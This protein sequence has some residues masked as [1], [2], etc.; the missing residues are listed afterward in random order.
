MKLALSWAGALLRVEKV[1]LV[2]LYFSENEQVLLLPST[3]SVMYH[4]V[5]VLFLCMCVFLNLSSTQNQTRWKALSFICN[6]KGFFVLLLL[7]TKSTAPILLLFFS[8]LMAYAIT[9]NSHFF[10]ATSNPV[11]CFRHRHILLSTRFHSHFTL[12]RAISFPTVIFQAEVTRGRSQT[13]LKSE[14]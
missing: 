11:T 9:H 13:K 10:T 12:F 3:P 5:V 2:K 14:E 8:S 4:N 7:Y 6:N 1:K